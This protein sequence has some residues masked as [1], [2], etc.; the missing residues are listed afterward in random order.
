MIA[1]IFVHIHFATC[2]VNGSVCA[3]YH[4]PGITRFQLAYYIMYDNAILKSN[5]IPESTF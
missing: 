4:Q 2:I 5:M 3:G 1:D